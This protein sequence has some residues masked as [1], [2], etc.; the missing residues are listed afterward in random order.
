MAASK[1]STETDNNAGSSTRAETG[2]ASLV[3]VDIE[4]V[5]MR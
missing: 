4:L 1:L 3:W 2:S 5:C